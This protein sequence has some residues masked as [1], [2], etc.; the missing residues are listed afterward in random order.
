MQWPHLVILLQ[1]NYYLYIMIM[2]Y[3]GTKPLERE[4]YQKNFN[5]AIIDKL[6]VASLLMSKFSGSILYDI[7]MF[8]FYL[9][10]YV[11]I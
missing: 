7:F 1:E 2:F 5:F 9:I 10:C 11:L 3:K 6:A 8:E 4:Y